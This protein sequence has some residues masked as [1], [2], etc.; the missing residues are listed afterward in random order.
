[1]VFVFKSFLH[2]KIYKNRVA[3]AAAFFYTFI[4][5]QNQ[6]GCKPAVFSFSLYFLNSWFNQAFTVQRLLCI[7]L[8]RR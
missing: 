5:P 1:M 2:G 3:A 6:V 8:H 7:Q 4:L